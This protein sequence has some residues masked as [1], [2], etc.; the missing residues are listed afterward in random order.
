MLPYSLPRRLRHK[1]FSLIGIA[2]LISSVNAQISLADYQNDFDQCVR[3]FKSLHTNRYIYVTEKEYNDFTTVQRTKITA[4]TTY[5]EF[6][7]LIAET[8][9]FVQ[10]YHSGTQLPDDRTYDRYIPLTTHYDGTQLRTIKGFATASQIPAGSKILKVN[11]EPVDAIIKNLRKYTNVDG[12]IESGIQIRLSQD[13]HQLY[14]A[15]YQFPGTYRIVY[16]APN[17]NTPVTRTTQAVPIDQLQ[18]SQRSIWPTSTGDWGLDFHYLTDSEIAILTVKHFGYDRNSTLF[19]NFIENTFLELKNKHAQDLIIDLRRNGGGDPYAADRLLS[20]LADKPYTYFRNGD[21][22]SELK[23][24][25]TPKKNR[26]SG[27]VYLLVDGKIGSSTGHFT[28]LVRYLDLATFVGTGT[29]A[30]Y[31]CSGNAT[32]RTLTNTKIMVRAGQGAYSTAV[33]GIPRGKAIEP[34]YAFQTSIDEIIENEDSLL[35]YTVALIQNKAASA[36]VSP[37]MQG[38]ITREGGLNGT[39]TATPDIGYNFTGWQEL[40]GSLENPILFTDP[41]QN[42]I[43]LTA[44]FIKDEIDQDKDGLSNY[45]EEAI[46]QTAGDI[47]DSDSD[48]LSDG[49]EASLA[50]L[51]F[52]PLVDDSARIAAL[53]ANADLIASIVGNNLATDPFQDIRI[54][55]LVLTPNQQGDL[56]LRLQ[57]QTMNE[58]YSWSDTYNVFEVEFDEPSSGKKFVRLKANSL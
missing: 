53:V 57:L 15:H 32:T 34:D 2:S 29:G 55:G 22:Y 10:C 18:F 58:N 37:G 4:N 13:F 26:F 33:S 49:Q 23:R 36:I 41:S 43:S 51:G 35:K 31:F 19:N 38:T 52:D 14:A 24:Q 50:K 9:S 44:T 39:F 7:N 3:V 6:Y 8:V 25:S 54:D 16:K 40:D 5:G 11:G 47:I 28:S 27:N 42:P 45:Q 48:S 21:G 17:S 56:T 12:H 46:Y 30:T 1:L 20:Y